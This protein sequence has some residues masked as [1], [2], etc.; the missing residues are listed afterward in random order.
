ML[1]LLLLL[2]LF[3][4]RDFER[5][6]ASSSTRR[7][8]SLARLKTEERESGVE[9]Y[10]PLFGDGELYGGGDGLWRDDAIVIDF[11]TFRVWN[12]PA[13]VTPTSG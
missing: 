8:Y 4:S 12:R 5:R 2:L 6:R 10:T 7:V 13:G 9:R 1:L 3:R 11:E